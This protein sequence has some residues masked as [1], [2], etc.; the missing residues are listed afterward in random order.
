MGCVII[1][2]MSAQAQLSF[3]ILTGLAGTAIALGTMFLVLWQAPGQRRNQLMAAY[4]LSLALWGIAALGIR[5]AV[6]SGQTPDPYF[7]AAAWQFG[8]GG[9]LLLGL[10]L[11]EGQQH[12][13]RWL[14]ASGL[15]VMATLT[16]VFVLDLQGRSYQT[17]TIAPD[18]SFT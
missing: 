6:V 10:A 3:S 12:P 15:I 2:V 7:H 1:Q 11:Y 17:L 8:L 16:I 4:L 13:N 5:L 18:G 14:V 9:W